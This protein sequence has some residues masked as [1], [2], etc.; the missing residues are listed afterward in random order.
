[1]Y[2]CNIYYYI[3]YKYTTL[4]YKKKVHDEEAVDTENYDFV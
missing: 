2:L 3:K 1:M 4:F